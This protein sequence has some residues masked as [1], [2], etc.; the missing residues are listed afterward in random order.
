[1]YTHTQ[2][3]HLQEPNAAVVMAGGRVKRGARRGGVGER[4]RDSRGGV[5]ERERGWE[6]E[7]ARER[8]G[9]GASESVSASKMPGP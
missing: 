9:D 7:N 6:R 3:C 8:V 4:E 5:R 1:M 2:Y